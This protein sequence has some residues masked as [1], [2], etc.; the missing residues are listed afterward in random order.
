LGCFFLTSDLPATKAK[1]DYETVGPPMSH[2]AKAPSDTRIVPLTAAGLIVMCVSLAILI[3]NIGFQGD[4]WWQFSWP[5]WHSFPNSVWEYAKASRRPVEGLYTVLAFEAFGLNRVFYTLSALSLSAGA[6][7]LMG[8]CLRRAFPGRE[9]LAVL[10]VFFAFLLTPVSNL[11]YMFHT[12]NSRIS[13][14]L[15][16]ASV[17]AFQ[18][19]ARDS[20]SWQ[21]LIIPA[22]LY[23]LATFT[24]ENTT[25]L[26]F[27]IPLMVWPIHVSN[28][29]DVSDSAFL[30][31]VF[32]GI[33]VA[34]TLFVGVRFAVFSGGAVGHSSLAPPV[35]LIWSYVSNLALYCFTPFSYFSWDR[36]AW[37]WGF[38]VALVA[39][40]LLG[41]A[42]KAEPRMRKAPKSVEESSPYIAM[43]GIIV[44][45]LG[46]LPYLMAGYNSWL[47]FTS[48][49]RIYSS[50]SF[51][52][53]ILLALTFSTSA[54]RLI[55]SLKKVIAVIII[56]VMAVFLA[57]LRDNWQKAA[58][59]RDRLYASLLTQVPNVAPGTTFLFLD[60]Q[61]YLPK[62]GIGRAVVAQGVDGIEEFIK[63]LYHNKDLDAYFLYPAVKV[64][65]D[66]KG[67]KASV[68][69]DGLVARGSAARP[70]IPLDSLLIFKRLGDELVLVDKLSS[71][72][73]SVAIEWHGV[74][75]VRSN[76]KLILPGSGM[77]GQL[78]GR[79]AR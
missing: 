40:L 24:Y 61:S 55:L 49:S 11:I 4:D 42:A 28:R 65:N 35:G 10:S 18:R 1:T 25:F 75:H 73:R 58:V 5:Y 59:K 76:R 46:M 37:M 31:R 14:L 32:G 17:W 36:M 52:L 44:L 23:L 68:S 12:D 15:F 39:A 53:A 22:S 43:L 69:P 56:A 26:I 30:V 77:E 34:F 66:T 16:W 57:G 51:G 45:A 47:G 29:N 8:T 74:S 71:D 38:F 78:I 6:C 9:S 2:A 13:I 7:L 72:D 27:S 48:Q 64:A 60:L 79:I 70:P 50:G 62:R 19:W 41:R 20:K 54:G 33:A 67:R 63:M 3:G 21:G